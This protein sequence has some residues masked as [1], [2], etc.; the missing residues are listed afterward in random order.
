MQLDEVPIDLVVLGLGLYGHV[1]FD[2]PG[3][4]I[5][6]GVP[7]RCSAPHDP[8]GRRR[9]LR[10]GLARVPEEALTVGLPTLLAARELLRRTLVCGRSPRQGCC[11]RCS[12]EAPSKQCPAS[13]LRQHPRLTVVCDRAAARLPRPRFELIELLVR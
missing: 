9:R 8:R 13:L 4:P 10:R 2:E 3:S 1:A 6:A 11:A 12:E 7:G 5:D